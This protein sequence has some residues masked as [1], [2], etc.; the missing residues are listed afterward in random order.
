MV[1]VTARQFSNL[2]ASV[3]FGISENVQLSAPVVDVTLGLLPALDFALVL[4]PIFE[5]GPEE[6]LSTEGA[7]TLALKWQPIRGA[8]WN[9]AFTPAVSLVFPAEAETTLTLPVQVEYRWSRFAIGGDGSEYVMSNSSIQVATE[10]VLLAARSTSLST[11]ASAST[12][13]VFTN[14]R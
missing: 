8:H 6:R 7:M 13:R 11:A 14:I 3:A 4:N 2:I 5:L 10:P 9:A 1:R 12:T